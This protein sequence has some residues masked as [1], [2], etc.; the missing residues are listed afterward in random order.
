MSMLLYIYLLLLPC[1]GSIALTYNGLNSSTQLRVGHI[2]E[3]KFTFSLRT[4]QTDG[5]IM[6]RIENANLYFMIGL[7]QGSLML[8]AKYSDGGNILNITGSRMDDGEWHDILVSTNATNT[9]VKDNTTSS[10][11]SVLILNSNWLSLLSNQTMKIGLNSDA[12]VSSFFGRTAYEGCVKN[13]FVGTIFHDVS[14]GTSVNTLSNCQSK[15]PCT[16]SPC[17][18]SSCIDIFNDFKCECPTFY[19]KK[20]C[21]ET[22]NISCAFNQGLCGNGTCADLN[23]ASTVLPTLS[24]NGGDFFKCE[25]NK[26]FTDKLCKT[27]IDECNLGYCSTTN[28]KDCTDLIADYLCNCKAGWEGKNCTQDINECDASPCNNDATCINL[29]N[30]F[31]CN[32]TAGFEG[33]TCDDDIDECLRNTSECMNQSECNNTKGNYTCECKPGYFGT[34]CEYNNTEACER[35]SPCFN[36]GVCSANTTGWYCKCVGEYLGLRCEKLAV[37]EDDDNLALIIG[38]SVGAAV[39]IILI[40]IFCLVRYCRDKSGME[41]TYSPNKEEQQS[42]NVEMNTLK[43]PNAERLI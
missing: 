40:V 29:E 21:N 31:K 19:T 27:N 9:I 24:Q 7:K 12:L 26:G 13:L 2:N 39:L 22:N 14:N 3:T 5:F 37:K 34:R 42:G 33:A 4:R 28:S 10:Q 35:L 17:V 36:E 18:K 16:N 11:F 38:V 1:T 41:G 23:I 6:G 25:C 8:H 32:C 30:N 20:T 15:N 43:K